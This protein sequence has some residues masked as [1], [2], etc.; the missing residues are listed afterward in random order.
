MPFGVERQTNGA[1][2]FRLWAPAADRVELCL[3]TV[4]K[5]TIL[6]MQSIENGWFDLTT[7]RAPPG[8]WYRY[9]INGDRRVP[10]PAS[11]HQPQ[12][13][14][15]PSEVIDP[16]AWIWTDD[17]WRGRPWEE[18]V[19]YELHVGAFTSA[20]N[21]TGVKQRLD[22]LA[23]LG[24]TAIEL[25]PVA[26]FPGHRNWGYDGVLPF[27]PDSCYG[28]PEDL[29]DLVQTAHALG[30]MVFLDVV[31]N[32]FGPDGNYLHLYAP[33]FFTNRHHTP[34][35]AAINFDGPES[36]T[37]REFFIH[38]A[39]YWLEE[40]HLDGL[41][42]DAVHAI[43]DDSQPDIL[44]EIAAA[45]ASGPGENRQ[46][47]L[48]LE[49]DNNAVRYLEHDSARRRHGYTAQW[50]DDIHHALHVL[51]TGETTGYYEDCSDAPLCHLGRCLTEGFAYQ[52]EPS[53]YRHS[54]PRGESTQALRLTAFISFLQNHDQ[55]G[56]RALGE[57]ITQLAPE[58]AVKAAMAILLLAPSPPLLFMGQEMGVTQPFLFFCDFE[59]DLAAAVT[60]GRRQ[61]FANFPDFS[62][63]AERMRIPDPN[64]ERTFLSSRLNWN[65]L[66]TKTNQEWRKFYRELISRRAREIVPRLRGARV[67][68][69]S[70]NVWRE[71]VL[72][73]HWQ[74]NEDS[75][76]L[77]A[78][79]SNNAISDI[80]LPTGNILYSTPALLND[81]ELS[82]W[83]VA[84]ILN[85]A[86]EL[87]I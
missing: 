33:T 57:R 53:R 29:K 83:S 81:S 85:S 30:L 76:E 58:A 6:P 27:A 1:M 35:G 39:L 43:F 55:V 11:R 45:V 8:T 13:V 28:R 87:S 47:H 40:Y 80:A 56:N 75:L 7:D 3:E 24:I 73:V 4:T 46:V 22:K 68:A 70:Y 74:L 66:K 12:D 18:A 54:V 61:E 9:R 63:A 32:H 25:M 48:I 77:L 49:N 14:H 44:H 62:G 84:W 17:G 67:R 36:R 38:N 41:R 34:W 5:E 72:R 64:D 19:I 82:A 79:L 69:A 59:H 26:D 31:Y 15:G 10:D 23:E 60:Q 2:Q 16:E 37:V 78:N 50:N 21:F 51:I 65:I 42:F 52:G 20:G 71:H 86:R